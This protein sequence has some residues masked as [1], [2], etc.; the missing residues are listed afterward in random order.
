MNTAPQLYGSQADYDAAL[1]P[2][3]PPEAPDM[4]D[5][6]QG[7]LHGEDADLLTYKQLKAA[8]MDRIWDLLNDDYVFEFMRSS[9]VSLEPNRSLAAKPIRKALEQIA[10]QMLDEAHAEAVK[11]FQRNGEEP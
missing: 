3:D 11:E 4:S 8:A 2:E 10:G 7:L 9:A 1:P 6:I 5:D